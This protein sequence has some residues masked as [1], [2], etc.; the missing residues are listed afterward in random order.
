MSGRHLEPSGSIW[1][2]FAVPRGE[3]GDSGAFEIDFCLKI[4]L[5]LAPSN[6]N[7]KKPMRL[8]EFVIKSRRFARSFYR[9]W[10]FYEAFLKVGFTKYQ[11][12]HGAVALRSSPRGD[13]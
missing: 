13:I 5:F 3:E 11:F 7:L 4:I 8:Y 6:E 9:K 12:S 2:H 10:S 1:K